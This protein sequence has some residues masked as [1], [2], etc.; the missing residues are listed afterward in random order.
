MLSDI[1]APYLNALLAKP[2]VAAPI[3]DKHNYRYS[4]QWRYGNAEAMRLVANGVR[5][6]IP[7]YALLLPSK[8]V[9]QDIKRLPLI[10]GYTWKRSD[11]TDT[12]AVIVTLTKDVLTSTLE[13]AFHSLK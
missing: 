3:D 8:D 6:A 13:P 10:Q 5:R 4:R 12:P 11:R 1:D 2:F 9:D 7:V